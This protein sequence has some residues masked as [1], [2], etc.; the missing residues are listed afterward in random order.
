MGY[1]IVKIPMMLF[2]TI[3]LQKRYELA[4]YKVAVHDDEILDVLYTKKNRRGVQ[5]LFWSLG[6]HE[7]L[8]KRQFAERRSRK[9]TE[10]E[11][12]LRSGR[13]EAP[14]PYEDVP[15]ACGAADFL[16]IIHIVNIIQE[17]GE[18]DTTRRQSSRIR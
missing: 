6:L 13:A 17:K 11:L 5:Q 14:D 2:S 9:M 18:P 16:R 7:M 4:V 1:G 3:K 10:S 15:P 8:V 12:L